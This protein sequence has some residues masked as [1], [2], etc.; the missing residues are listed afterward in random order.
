MVTRATPPGSPNLDGMLSPYLKKKRM[1]MVLPFI[2]VG[3]R[4]LDIGCDNGALLHYLPAFEFYFGLDSREASI[5]RNRQQYK[6]SNVAFDCKDFVEFVWD[7]VPFNLIV[8]AAVLEHLED[9]DATFSRLH[10]ILS[11]K[12]LLVIT[13]PTPISRFILQSGAPFRLFASESLHE[14][15]NYFRKKNFQN[16]P[17]WEL[18]YYKRFEFG[19]NQLVVMRKTGEPPCLPASAEYL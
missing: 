6:Q 8:M 16:L 2:P 3:S 1:R 12:G 17:D 4:I 11:D 5:F 14:H 15:K 13:T 19:L 9:F 18:S 7:D 10:S